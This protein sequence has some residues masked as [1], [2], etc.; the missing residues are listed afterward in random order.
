MAQ[1][2]LDRDPK[3]TQHLLAIEARSGKLARMDPTDPTDRT[4]RPASAPTPDGLGSA[5]PVR[6]MNPHDQQV[7]DRGTIVLEDLRDILHLSLIHI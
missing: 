2:P 1:P 4:D 6:L 3:L 5:A 7:Q